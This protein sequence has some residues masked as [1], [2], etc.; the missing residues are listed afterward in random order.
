MTSPYQ[1]NDTNQKWSPSARELLY[2]ALIPQSG[3]ELFTISGEARTLASVLLAPGDGLSDH[4]RR[5]AEAHPVVEYS[6]RAD[7]GTS[8]PSPS[9]DAFHHGTLQWAIGGATHI[10]IWSAP[11]PQHADEVAMWG[12]RAVEDGARFVTTVETTPERSHEW[13]ELVQRWKRPSAIVRV[14]GIDPKPS[15]G[16]EGVS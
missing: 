10:V 8:R 2:S 5:L 12:M 14:F 16:E 7:Y 9:P 3:A 4:H 15:D 6:V 13:M 11:Y 1:G